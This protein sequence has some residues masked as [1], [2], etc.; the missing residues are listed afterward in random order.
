MRRTS[1]PVTW[2]AYA[3]Q[4]RASQASHGLVVGA[5]IGAAGPLA[6][7]GPIVADRPAA[8]KP[9]PPLRGLSPSATLG[10]PGARP[11]PA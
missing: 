6:G 11:S 1:S 5:P 4:Q 9:R 2:T 10:L 8:R 7:G 3:L